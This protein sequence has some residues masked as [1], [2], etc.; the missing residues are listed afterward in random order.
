MG[1]EFL[2]KQ[3]LICVERQIFVPTLE[4]F[5]AEEGYGVSLYESRK[6]R[7][8][9]NQCST[10]M[11]LAVLNNAALLCPNNAL[12]ELLL[13]SYFNDNI[14]HMDASMMSGFKPSLS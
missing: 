1:C 13:I 12:S 9:T 10:T 2:K 14:S 6:K 5:W 3:A 4:M 8:Q 7:M 11:L